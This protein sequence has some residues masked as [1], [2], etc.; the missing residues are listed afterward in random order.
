MVKCPCCEATA[1]Y[2]N[3][4]E[5]I[6]DED[7]WNINVIRHYHCWTCHCS[8]S[9]TSVYTCVDQHEEIKIEEE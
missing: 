8:F 9:L 3:E 1:P 7:G 2:V 4:L 6:Y 5:T